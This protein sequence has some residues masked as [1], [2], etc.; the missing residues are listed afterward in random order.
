MAT[1]MLIWGF[2]CPTENL[3]MGLFNCCSVLL[4]AFNR[5]CRIRNMAVSQSCEQ[6]FI[7]YFILFF[8]WLYLAG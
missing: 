5:H 8:F 1:G 7:F 4:F 2:D 3:D 6:L